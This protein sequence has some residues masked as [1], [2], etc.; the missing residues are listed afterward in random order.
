[1]GDTLNAGCFYTLN[2]LTRTVVAAELLHNFS[3]NETALAIGTQ[4]APFPLTLFKARLNTNGAVGALV[5]HQ[6]WSK[7]FV[8]LAGEVDAKAILGI[9]KIGF[10]LALRP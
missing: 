5:Q 7:L 2:T 6:L 4:H 9:P 10:S 1:M 8:T 3:R